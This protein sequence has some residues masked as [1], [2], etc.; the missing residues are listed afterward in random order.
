[1]ELGWGANDEDRTGKRYGGFWDEGKVLFILSRGY[2]Y[3][4]T[5]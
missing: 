4:L 3:V 1:M 2:V 5:L